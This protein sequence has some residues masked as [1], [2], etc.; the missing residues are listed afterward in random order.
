MRKRRAKELAREKTGRRRH[1]AFNW[2]RSDRRELPIEFLER[3]DLLTVVELAERR[4]L[5]EGF[6]FQFAEGYAEVEPRASLE[7]DVFLP[8]P[9]SETVLMEISH[10]QRVVDFKVEDPEGLEASSWTILEWT[11]DAGSSNRV[12]LSGKIPAGSGTRHLHFVANEEDVTSYASQ[13]GIRTYFDAPWIDLASAPTDPV[14]LDFQSIGD[15]GGDSAFY[16]AACEPTMLGEERNLLSGPWKLSM[17]ESLSLLG[18]EPQSQ[19]TDDEL[20]VTTPKLPESA[21]DSYDGVWIG[22]ESATGRLRARSSSV[23]PISAIEI[24]ND[25]GLFVGPTPNFTFENPFNVYRPTKLFSL[26]FPPH[27]QSELDFGPVLRAGMSREELVTKLQIAGAYQQGGTWSTVVFSVDDDI[28]FEQALENDFQ[29][30]T[31]AK[32]AAF[33]ESQ[34]ELPPADRHVIEVQYQWNDRG[35]GAYPFGHSAFLEYRYT[36]DS[37]W[38]VLQELTGSDQVTTQVSTIDDYTG[39]LFLR[40]V[41]QSND[42]VVSIREM[43]VRS[44]QL[45]PPF[46]IVLDVAPGELLSIDTTGGY[47]HLTDE[48]GETVVDSNSFVALGV[49]GIDTERFYLRFASCSPTLQ[50]SVFRSHVEEPPVSPPYIH[51]IENEAIL[52]FNDTIDSRT[53]DLSTITWD[54]GPLLEV[55]ASQSSASLV[56]TP[57]QKVGD[58][59]LHIPE[60]ICRMTTGAWL[61]GGDYLVDLTPPQLVGGVSQDLGV[62]PLGFPKITLDFDELV[63][64]LDFSLNSLQENWAE[65][66]GETGT[67]YLQGRPVYSYIHSIDVPLGTLT[68]GS[69]TLTIRNMSVNDEQW[70]NATYPEISIRFVISSNVPESELFDLDHNGRVDR[71]DLDIFSWLVFTARS[72]VADLNRDGQSDHRDFGLWIARSNAFTVGDVNFDGVFNQ[73]DLDWM[74]ST[75]ILDAEAS[76]FE[77]DFD[78]D[79]F[80]TTADLTLAMQGGFSEPD[81]VEI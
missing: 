75:F 54:G 78:G 62:L 32:Y 80:Y 41:N 61:P 68:E 27:G 34:I 2:R 42:T 14:H 56:F 67:T 46:P 8:S 1:A 30:L 28:P 3:R 60:R 76:W 64:W 58:R 81:V 12:L 38:S 40:V 22:Y 47:F 44:Y 69:Y 5:A 39:P 51:V 43:S 35:A 36:E 53:C 77:G 73:V 19:S 65:I 9:G 66:Q 55:F 20:S 23:T 50:L 29:P 17:S 15:G 16:F 45:A 18:V 10:V 52:I 7:L 24:K 25:E 11:P 31:G 59:V 37:P 63:H 13:I 4:P 71:M 57:D 6:P 21:I 33:A 74:A 79:G 70:N 26:M 48:D 72:P 49:P